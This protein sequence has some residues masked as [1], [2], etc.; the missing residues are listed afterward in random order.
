MSK[1]KIF[2]FK[3]KKKKFQIKK[4]KSQKNKFC[5]IK[6]SIRKKE[7]YGSKIMKYK[8]KLNRLIKLNDSILIKKFLKTSISNLIRKS[9]LILKRLLLEIKFKKKKQIKKKY[10]KMRFS[11]L[12]NP[13]LNLD[14]LRNFNLNI[15]QKKLL[16]KLISRFK[17]KKDHLRFNWYYRCNLR[18]EAREKRLQQK[19]NSLRRRYKRIFS[20]ILVKNLPLNRKKYLKRHFYK[21]MKSFYKK[22]KIDFTFKVS[23]SFLSN[24]NTSLTIYKNQNILNFN[25]LLINSYSLCGFNELLGFHMRNYVYIFF[26]FFF[27][28][29]NS[30]IQENDTFSSNFGRLYSAERGLFPGVPEYYRTRIR[31][32]KFLCEKTFSRII[33]LYVKEF[34]DYVVRFECL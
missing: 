11:H 2:K 23:F 3:I 6:T 13:S 15:S 14:F 1:K 33:E 21:F 20:L 25:H 7:I 27:F 5:F 4:L 32:Y 26:Y 8:L 18:S 31:K 9:K 29:I 28:K 16:I 22:S 12:Y 34:L 30:L 17:I 19:L 10:F 24:F